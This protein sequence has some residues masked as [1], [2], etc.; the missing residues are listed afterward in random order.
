MKR[1]IASLSS[2]TF[3]LIVIGGGIIGSGIARDAAMRGIKTL[4]LEKDDFSYGTTSRSS[5]LIHGGLRYLRQLEFKLVRQDMREREVLLRIAPHLVHPLP[6]IIPITRS[7]DRVALP[8]GM[9]LYDLLSFDKSMPS[10]RHL[11]K[12]ETLELEPNLDIKGLSGSY[13]YYDCQAPFTERL[14]LENVISAAQHGACVLNHTKVTGILTKGDTVYG[15]E[16]QDMLTGEKYQAKGRLVVNAAGPWVDTIT[17]LLNQSIEPMIRRT[18]GIHILVPQISRHAVVCFA[19]SDGRLFFV[20]PWQGYSLIGTTDTDYFGDS[21]TVHAEAEDVAYLVSETHRNFPSLKKDDIWYSTAGLRALAGDSSK[22]ASD[23]TRAHR[24]VDHEKRHGIRGFVS[25]LGGKITGYRAIAEEVVNLVCHKLKLKATCHT[26]EIALPGA[27]AVPNEKIESVARENNLPVKT[28]SHL[29]SL[30]GSRFSQVVNLASKN[31]RASEPI[32]PHCTDILAQVEYAATEEAALTVG[33][34]L[35]R[36]SDV[37][38]APCQGL[39][40]V[41]KV[42]EEMGRILGWSK[43]EQQ[44]QIQ[45]YRQQIALNMLFRT[46]G[47]K[48]QIY[49]QS[50]RL[51]NTN[52]FDRNVAT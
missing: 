23:V 8:I 38:L 41:E 50:D 25:V 27:P 43:D 5:R 17:A 18:K 4:L 48:A 44:K 35:L 12:R 1:D 37:G 2:E 34:F 39:D 11:S 14:C 7:I 21:D 46:T 31:S 13:V 15:V 26:A 45:A 30:Y 29:A 52:V 3:D 16:T 19:Q 9:L 6:F 28:V 22:K 51:H 33:D 32:C 40:A 49:K 42:A 36:R 10:H 47:P 20:I 24:I